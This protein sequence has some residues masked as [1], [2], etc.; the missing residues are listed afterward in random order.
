MNDQEITVKQSN[1][2]ANSWATTPKDFILKYIRYLPWVVLSVAIALCIAWVKL[3]YSIPY[4]SAHGS[5]L[6][7]AETRSTSND[8]LDE[9]LQS[10]QSMNIRNEVEVLK[11]TELASRVVKAL[12]LGTQY[13]NIGKVKYYVLYNNSPFRLELKNES[14]TLQ[15]FSIPLTVKDAVHFT[16]KGVKRDF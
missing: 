9:L 11:S 7:R 15:P 10:K 6:I 14:D 1:W 16:I 13:L 2:K 4:Y 5:M 8:K 3:R 12:G